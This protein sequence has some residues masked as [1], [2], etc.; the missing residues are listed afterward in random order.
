[1]KYIITIDS[2]PKSIAR[3]PFNNRVLVGRE[4]GVVSVLDERAQSFSNYMSHQTDVC[5]YIQ[6]VE[7]DL[8]YIVGNQFGFLV[9]K[10]S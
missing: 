7:N 9:Y 2:F 10:T 8:R 1:M 4:D 6:V 5:E 3:D